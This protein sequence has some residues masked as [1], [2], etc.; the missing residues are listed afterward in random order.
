MFLRRKWPGRTPSPAEVTGRTDL[1]P[2]TME[3]GRDGSK[4]WVVDK[5]PASGVVW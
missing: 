1:S 3:E 5:V 4:G 2:M